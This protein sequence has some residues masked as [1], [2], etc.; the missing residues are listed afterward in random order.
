MASN[1]YD[2]NKTEVYHAFSLNNC[3]D[4]MALWTYFAEP[5]RPG[6][7][8]P[9][10]AY[11]L[12]ITAL[13]SFM[14]EHSL[15]AP[16]YPEGFSTWI[17]DVRI[18]RRVQG[19]VMTTCIADYCRTKEWDG[20]PDIAGIGML[21][22][23][24]IQAMLVTIYIIG[25][26]TIRS[27]K[28]LPKLRKIP[29]LFRVLLAL[30]HSLV[31]LLS[32]CFL[33]SIA[34]LLA[35]NVSLL[36]DMSTSTMYIL[37][38]SM[39]VNSVLPAVLLQLV[40]TRLLRRSRGRILAWCVVL[41]LAVTLFV[42][43]I[44]AKFKKTIKAEEDFDYEARCLWP[45][46]SGLIAPMAYYSWVIAG[47]QLL[48]ISAYIVGLLNSQRNRSLNPFD[49]LPRSVW[50]TLLGLTFCAMWTSIGLFIRL[51]LR[52][53]D[54]VGEKNKDSEWSFGQVLALATWV[55]S[56]V[57]FVYI[58]WE[59]P[60]EALNGR[61]MD[62]YEVCETSREPRDLEMR[63]AEDEQDRGEFRRLIQGGPHE[64]SIRTW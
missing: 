14:R 4:V 3:S 12:T 6:G 39:P 34:M 1:L 42:G 28:L 19:H 10:K 24:V 32:A 56:I 44:V 15:R 63:R 55:P 38:I 13:D 5:L 18:D 26:I 40:G 36:Q 35:G 23:Y 58:W 20:N 43:T 7:I 27:E 31:D 60:E 53:H 64:G 21:A 48:G 41:A 51:T 49:W 16:K 8:Y 59:A 57:E 33:F 30:K 61:L 54:R 29:S 45:Y 25:I 37:I 50:W 62:P 2:F 9:K 52:I 46:I 17:Q 11:N 22:T 47:F